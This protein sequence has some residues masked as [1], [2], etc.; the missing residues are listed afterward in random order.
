MVEGCRALV[1]QTLSL[2]AR[3]SAVIICRNN[4]PQASGRLRL[5]IAQTEGLLVSG[6]VVYGL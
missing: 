6:G 1:L 5:I 2:K 4:T 3:Y